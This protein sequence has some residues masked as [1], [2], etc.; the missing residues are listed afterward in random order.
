MSGPPKSFENAQEVLIVGLARTGDRDAFSELVRRR[1]AWVRSLMRRLCGDAT[2][3]D[4]L[5]QQVFMKAWRDIGRIREPSRFPGWL[6]RLAINVWREHARRNDPLAHAR[7]DKEDLGARSNMG[8]S[9]DLD[10]AL[11][12]LAA[13]GPAPGTT[14]QRAGQRPQ[15]ASVSLP[16]PN[17]RTW[18][19]W[20]S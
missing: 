15:R 9:M 13:H 20:V 8:L 1:Q 5:A 6:K 3:A 2:L 14:R 10:A 18:R 11:A 7:D 19:E 12:T 4:D 16:S 17:L